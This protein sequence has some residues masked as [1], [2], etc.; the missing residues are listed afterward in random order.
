MK[1]EHIQWQ[2]NRWEPTAPGRLP[3][4][5]VVFLFGSPSVLKHQHLLQQVQSAYPRAH[6]LG[7]STAGGISHTQVLD[8]SLIATAVQF[9]QTAIRG[10]RVK[11]QFGVSDFQTGEQ[12][13]R[14]LDTRGLVHVFVLSRGLNVNGSDLVAGLA[15]H[16]PS[17]VTITGGLA[18]D[19]AR[20]QETMIIWEGKIESE[21]IVILGFY[22]QRLRVG[23]GSFGGWDAFGPPLLITRSEGNLLFEL[24]GKSALSVYKAYLGEQAQGLPATGLLFPL[25]LLTPDS[26][27]P[28]VRTILSV[29]EEEESITFAGDVPEGMSTRM[30]RASFDRL[31][32]GAMSAAKTSSW[33]LRT[34]PE[35]AILISC[36]GRKLLLKQRIDEEVKG[37][38]A[39][40]GDQTVITGFY[41]YGEISPFIPGSM[42]KLHNQTMTIT[43]FSER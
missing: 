3:N 10:I 21:S 29:D 16:L 9:E 19:D 33:T 35:L 2:N 30:M 4:A 13:A 27:N 25:C 11:P 34:V 23:C 14:K 26:P 40:M 24:N 5:Q 42:C 8:D 12:L 43:T 6:L 20:F 28:V 15:Q 31:I 18:G 36:V 41:S 39:V 32:G 37:V 17:H 1:I 7:C 38:R 22:S